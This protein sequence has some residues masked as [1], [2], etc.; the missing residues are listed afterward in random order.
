MSLTIVRETLD[1]HAGKRVASDARQTRWSTC[2]RAGD[3]RLARRRGRGRRRRE[4]RGG[5]GVERSRALAARRR[6][7]A[8]RGARRTAGRRRPRP[9]P[10]ARTARDMTSRCSTATRRSGCERTPRSARPTAG[11]SATAEHMPCKLLYTYRTRPR[12]SSTESRG[13]LL[14]VE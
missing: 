13:C 12:R 3:P 10:A 8:D 4:G 9:A 11:P 7:R 6:R 2:R 1:E 5:A 14:F